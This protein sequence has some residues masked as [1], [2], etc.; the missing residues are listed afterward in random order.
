MHAGLQALLLFWKANG[1]PQ[2]LLRMVRTR[3]I[4]HLPRYTR[5]IVVVDAAA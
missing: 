5:V 1:T 4:W 3:R 2:Q